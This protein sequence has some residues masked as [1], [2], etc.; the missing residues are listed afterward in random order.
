MPRVHSQSRGVTWIQDQHTCLHNLDMAPVV[1]A[2]L[3]RLRVVTTTFCVIPN[4]TGVELSDQRMRCLDVMPVVAAR[5]RRR[6]NGVAVST[7]QEEKQE[8]KQRGGG[9]GSKRQPGI[10]CTDHVKHMPCSQ[11]QFRTQTRKMQRQEQSKTHTRK[12]K[13]T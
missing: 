2:P 9:S 5:K 10:H 4:T 1:L 13:L 12:I 7:K 8:A 3:L 11:R 6:R